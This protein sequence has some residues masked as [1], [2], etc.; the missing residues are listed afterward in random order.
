MTHHTFCAICLAH[1]SCEGDVILKMW[2]V[3]PRARDRAGPPSSSPPA[4]PPLATR[5]APSVAP[6]NQPT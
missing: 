1:T 5:T 2:G 6:A 3:C 4:A